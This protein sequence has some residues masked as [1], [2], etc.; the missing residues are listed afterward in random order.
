MITYTVSGYPNNISDKL[1]LKSIKKYLKKRESGKLADVVIYFNNSGK[2][3]QH[4]I[5]K[6]KIAVSISKIDTLFD[7]YPEYFV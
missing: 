3:V 4:Y 7:M 2:K 1:K 6:G 5:D